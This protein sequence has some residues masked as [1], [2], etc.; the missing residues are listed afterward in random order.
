MRVGESRR[1]TI[2]A[3]S[4]PRCRS[5]SSSSTRE[6]NPSEDGDGGEVIPTTIPP[7]LPL[8]SDQSEGAEGVVYD[9]NLLK[10]RKERV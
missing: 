2:P 10:V 4:W 7:P 3:A 8:D 1:L 6:G 5:S 9:I